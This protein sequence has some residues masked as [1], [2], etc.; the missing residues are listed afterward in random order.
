MENDFSDVLS[1]GHILLDGGVGTEITRRGIEE[2]YPTIG[3][4]NALLTAPHVVQS[5]HED[6]LR[7]GA[8][9]I[10][11]NTYSTPRERLEEAGMSEQVEQINRRAG[12]LAQT[13]RDAVNGDALVAGS[14][15]PIRGSYRPDLVGS[16]SD[17]KPQYEEQAQ[18]LAPYVDLFLCE[19]MSRIREARA[20][21]LGAASADRPVLVAYTIPDERDESQPDGCLRSGESLKEAVDALADLPVSG[22][23]LNCSLPE[24]ITAA[25]PHL[26]E[27]T[28]RPVG[29]Y[30]NAFRGIPEDWNEKT[31]PDPE[32]REDLGPEEYGTYAR[33]WLANG[34]ELVGGCCEVGPEH[35]S[36]LRG[37]VDG[38]VP[39]QTSGA[40]T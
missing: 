37:I 25:I 39:P 21:V 6:Y 40:P 19:T 28:D 32:R 38:T 14:L 31:D 17:L 2:E 34:A 16:I 3:A 22:I 9:V 26:R 30:A 29:G 35:I 4:A 1:N 10:T 5:V 15:P 13:A 18:L 8:D 12:Q 24:R 23:L 33:K 27:H 7:A 36:Y 20:A 11:S